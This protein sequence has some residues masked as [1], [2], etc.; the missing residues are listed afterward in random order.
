MAEAS[1]NTAR[2]ATDTQKAVEQLVEMSTQLRGLVAQ[3]KIEAGESHGG[4]AVGDN[5]V[6]RSM[7]A[8]AST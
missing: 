4:I 5:G 2:G 6:A 8:H 3:F 1:Q 7:A